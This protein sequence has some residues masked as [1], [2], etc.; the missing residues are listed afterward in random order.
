MFHFGTEPFDM[1]TVPEGYPTTTNGFALTPNVARA[2]SQGTVRLRSANPA[3]P[4]R[5]DFATSPTR[6]ARRAGDGG[7]REAGP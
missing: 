1:N 7:G 3:D 2:K 6:R 4:P 5:I